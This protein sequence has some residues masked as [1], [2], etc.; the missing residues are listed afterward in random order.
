MTSGRIR[1]KD[2]GFR[3]EAVEQLGI[4]LAKLGLLGDEAG[5]PVLL[6]RAGPRPALAVGPTDFWA[7]R[8]LAGWLGRAL[9]LGTPTWPRFG[10]GPG[11]TVALTWPDTTFGD[12]P[13]ARLVQAVMLWSIWA[14]GDFARWPALTPAPAPAPPAEKPAPRPG[15]PALVSHTVSVRPGWPAAPPPRPPRAPGMPPGG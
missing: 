10:L 7:L 4:G 13:A 9:G 8:P 3:R 15:G 6:V 14:T 5:T 2:G 12:Q 11:P 1:L